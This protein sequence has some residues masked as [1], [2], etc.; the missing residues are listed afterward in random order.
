MAHRDTHT[1]THTDRDTHRETHQMFSRATI[2][3]STA[4]ASGTCS[5]QWSLYHI[6]RND[7]QSEQSLVELKEKARTN[8]GCGPLDSPGSQPAGYWR[9]VSS[10]QRVEDCLVKPSKPLY[11]PSGSK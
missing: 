2:A 3:L 9:L 4:S 10:P 11:S 7:W 1:E 8:S 6:V 5:S